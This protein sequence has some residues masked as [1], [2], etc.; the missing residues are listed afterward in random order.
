MRSSLE[1][2]RSSCP[3]AASMVRYTV[4]V[5][6]ASPKET[7]AG[8]GTCIVVIKLIGL[9]VGHSVVQRVD[10]CHDFSASSKLC[11]VSRQPGA[12]LEGR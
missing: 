10:N 7:F 3:N 12:K 8:I 4:G 11:L 2:S 9:Q 6:E 1:A 5:P